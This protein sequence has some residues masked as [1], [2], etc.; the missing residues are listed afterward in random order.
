M[1]TKLFNFL[2]KKTYFG[3]A[4]AIPGIIW[5]NFAAILGGVLILTRAQFE[6]T[7]TKNVF[8]FILFLGLMGSAVFV[9]IKCGLG[10]LFGKKWEDQSFK[11]LNEYIVKGEIPDNLSNQA[12][13]ETYNAFEKTYIFL[14][15]LTSLPAIG[16]VLSVA[17]AEYL[18]SGQLINV[19][20]ILIGG[21]IASF[22]STTYNLNYANEMMIPYRKKCKNL[23]FERNISFEERPLTDLKTKSNLFILLMVA[24][25]LIIFILIYPLSL[26]LVT[27]SL[28]GLIMLIMIIQT[29]IGSFSQALKEIEQSA[30]GLE[31]GGRAL[32]FSGS[33]DRE[34]IALSKSLNK[35]AQNIKRYQEKLEEEKAS[36][37]IKV[38]ARTKV[39][40]EEKALLDE[41][42]KERTK[43]LQE[44]I[45]ELEKFHKLTVGRELKMIEFKKEI[46]KLKKESEKNKK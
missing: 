16:V 34:I 26:S 24:V 45:N 29:I 1:I 17:L 37:E 22:I 2:V 46:K 7:G 19:P 12:L 43:E 4:I 25:F 9:L 41:R 18:F 33:T 5:G 39:V 44:R 3:I 15:K 23:L 30:K 31:T 11:A 6:V 10:R 40:E 20:I 36:L 28:V 21:A 35:T 27:V 38:K 32:F 14:S 42:V 13:L 8:I